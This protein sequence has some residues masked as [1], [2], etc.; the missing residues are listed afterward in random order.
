MLSLL[1]STP[2]KILLQKQNS[3]LDFEAARLAAVDQKLAA[4]FRKSA[5]IARGQLRVEENEAAAVAAAA[6]ELLRRCDGGGAEG[7][8]ST[9]SS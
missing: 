6:D 5:T 4:D 7:E 3:P 1:T 9:S 8:T 2:S